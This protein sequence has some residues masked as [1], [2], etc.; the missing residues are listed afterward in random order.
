MF[1]MWIM[2]KVNFT[3][4]GEWQFVEWKRWTPSSIL[5]KNKLTQVKYSINSHEQVL[6]VFS[7][8]TVW[9]WC[10]SWSSW[11]SYGCLP[12]FGNLTARISWVLRQTAV[13]RQ[14]HILGT[15]ENVFY[16]CKT[17]LV[18]RYLISLLTNK[19]YSW[20]YMSSDYICKLLNELSKLI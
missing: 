2:N 8:L 16:F 13:R 19:V 1:N 11:W 9:L 15:S 6:T 10:W 5:K 20:Y 7:K 18:F 17:V 14:I 12:T 4:S 3:F